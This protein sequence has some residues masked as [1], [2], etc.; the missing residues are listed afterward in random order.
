MDIKEK[1]RVIRRNFDEEAFTIVAKECVF[2]TEQVLR[3]L[4]RENLERL[5]EEDRV[6]FQKAE[7]KKGGGKRGIEQ[8]TMGQM[9]HLFKDSD[10]LDA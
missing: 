4:V 3:Q 9:V 5:S 6:R 7:A 2:L 8:F 10:F 1:M